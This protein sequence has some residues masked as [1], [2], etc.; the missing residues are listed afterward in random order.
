MPLGGLLAD[1]EVAFGLVAALGQAGLEL[2]RGLRGLGPGRLE[3]PLG[4]VALGGRLVGRLGS[5]LGGLLA[6]LLKQLRGLLAGLLAAGSG[7]L[8]GLGPDL[9]GRRFGCLAVLLGAGLSLDLEVLGFLLGEP[10]DL[11]YSGAKAGIARLGVVLLGVLQLEVQLLQAPLESADPLGGGGAFRVEPAEVIVHLLALV[12]AQH[13]VA[14]L[15]GGSVSSAGI[16]HGG[17]C[18]S[19]Q[20]G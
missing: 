16:S 5:H 12:L 20:A 14:G 9:A 18:G 2:G 3:D 11:L 15:V 7:V 13:D 1:R 8:V 6:G 17:S 10:E 19:A 4:L